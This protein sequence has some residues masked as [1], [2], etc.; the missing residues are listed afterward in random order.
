MSYS[1]RVR[2]VALDGESALFLESC[3]GEKTLGD[4]FRAPVLFEA[5]AGSTEADKRRHYRDMISVML[6]GDLVYLLGS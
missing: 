3:D 6:A 4:V 5:L 1:A 2:D